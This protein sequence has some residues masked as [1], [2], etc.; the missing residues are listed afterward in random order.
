[1]VRDGRKSWI[2]PQTSDQGQLMNNLAI[3][4]LPDVMDAI[5][6]LHNAVVTASTNL[7]LHTKP[8]K[9]RVIKSTR[10]TRRG[11]GARN[12]PVQDDRVGFLLD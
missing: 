8:I 6:N 3:V 7:V 12:V 9:A 4:S 10:S 11:C 5:S 2:R 1:M